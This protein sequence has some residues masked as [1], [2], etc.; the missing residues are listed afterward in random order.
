MSA[1][2]LASAILCLIAFHPDDTPH[3]RTLDSFSISKMSFSDDRENFAKIKN[4]ELI[5]DD[6][7]LFTFADKDYRIG[8]KDRTTYEI[9]E[10]FEFNAVIK[11]FDSFI[12][13]CGNSDGTGATIVQYLGTT[14]MDDVEYF[15][16]WHTVIE[17]EDRF[18]C[19]YPQIIQ[20]SLNHDFGEL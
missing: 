17:P 14:T 9:T 4:M 11:K 20:H 19:K 15:M 6:T 16:T 12:T 8:N 3:W 13:H 2:I 7:A 10:D 5:D 18:S 1:G